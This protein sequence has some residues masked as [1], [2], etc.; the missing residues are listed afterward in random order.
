LCCCHSSSFTRGRGGWVTNRA[1]R[2]YESYESFNNC[3]S[4]AINP[5]QPNPTKPNPAFPCSYLASTTDRVNR[6][7]DNELP[8]ALQTAGVD[9]ATNRTLQECTVRHLHQ[10]QINQSPVSLAPA[11]PRRLQGLPR[12]HQHEQTHRDRSKYKRPMKI[13]TATKQIRL[14]EPRKSTGVPWP[15]NYYYETTRSSTT[16]TKDRYDWHHKTTTAAAKSA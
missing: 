8:R 4:A 5:I 11:T 7:L 10:E 15:P 14:Y 2:V 9:K 3:T 13:A 6:G 12:T 16:T 1:T